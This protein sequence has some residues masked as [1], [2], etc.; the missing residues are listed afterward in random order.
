[1]AYPYNNQRPPLHTFF[2]IFSISWWNNQILNY[3]FYV[4]GVSYED[5]CKKLMVMVKHN[6]DLNL[7]DP[8][9][10]KTISIY[11]MLAAIGPVDDLIP[12]G[13]DCP[14][15]PNISVSKDDRVDSDNWPH[16]YHKCWVET[17][18]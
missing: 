17:K 18:L 4:V 2:F 15:H 1:M 14:I 10:P 9:W 7:V 8:M 12:V 11:N 13:K 5:A 3:E 16:G 6:F